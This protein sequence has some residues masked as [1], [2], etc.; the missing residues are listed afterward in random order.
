MGFREM[1]DRNWRNMSADQRTVFLNELATATNRQPT[2]WEGV[3][4]RAIARIE[5]F[6][7]LPSDLHGAM[8]VAMIDDSFSA[9]EY[10]EVW[11]RK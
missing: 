2:Q 3:S 1:G 7:G 11:R 6:D 10:M 8:I 5:S 4:V 9:K